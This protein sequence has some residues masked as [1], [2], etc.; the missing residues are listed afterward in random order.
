MATGRAQVGAHVAAVIRNRGLRRVLI[1]FSVFRPFESAQWIA[2]LVYAF[3]R[4]GPKEMS[5]AVVVL[6]A[7]SAIAAPFLS[8]L[9]DVVDRERA[10]AVG[11]LVQGVSMGAVALAI[12]MATPAWVV[13]T[14]AAGANVAITITRP[15]HLAILPDLAVSPAEL[16]AANS[17]TS[18]IEGV[19]LLVGPVIA[20]V[21]LAL[22]G[23]GIVYGL[24]AIG[25]T[26]VGVLVLLVE[27]RNHA[28]AATPD[29]VGD[30]W[31]GFRELRRRP[32]ARLLLGFV[33][34]ETTVIGAV[35]SLIVVLAF[36]VL[37]MGPSGPGTLSAAVG[38]GGLIGAAGTVALVDRQR[39]SWPFF[40]GVV[41]VGIPLVFVAAVPGAVFAFLLLV[42]SGMGKSVL[43]VTSRTLLQRGVDDDVL[44]R[45]FGVQEGLNM[46]AL[47]VG[48]GLAPVVVSALSPLA[49]FVVVGSL[50]PAAALLGFG[51]IR[52]LDRSGI[53]V[54]PADLDLLR[55]TPIFEPLG[56]M[57][58][59]RAGRKLIGVDVAAGTVVTRQGE[60]GDRFYLVAQGEVEVRRSGAPIARLGAGQYFGE[61][62]LL[63]DAPRNATVVAVTPSS[64]R[65]I[66]RSAFLAIMTGSPASHASA[67]REMDRRL[68]ASS[69][70]EP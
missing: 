54:D 45:V 14:F 57:A 60:P 16:S 44:A 55:G 66:E 70:D 40:L 22:S 69:H 48:A 12:A 31:E 56:P 9:G 15:V 61:I 41:G 21:G 24:G 5:L 4:G 64:L 49:A 59:E 52:R 19:S 2:I 47:G 62:A 27:H 3:G 30:A 6:L 43:D 18:T 1:A 65:A 39:L 11:Y 53:V 36:D 17:L 34:G 25:L 46:V 63:R 68:R 42:V 67:T 13:F 37:S 51:P 33:A 35:D 58:L 29:R 7:P 28:P 23:P 32:G 8:Q 20:A 10:L 26:V 50:L 38:V